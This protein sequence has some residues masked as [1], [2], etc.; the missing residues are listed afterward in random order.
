M[1]TLPEIERLTA[2]GFL[3]PDGKTYCCRF[4]YLG[5]SWEG[6]RACRCACANKVG[7]PLL[8]CAVCGLHKPPLGRSVAPEAA[9]GMCSR[10]CPGYEQWPCPGSLWPNEESV[11]S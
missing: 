8:D 1:S 11:A 3:A 2:A 4:H 5:G 6:E 9:N 7:A 10:D